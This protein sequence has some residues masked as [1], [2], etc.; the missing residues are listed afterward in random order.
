NPADWSGPIRNVLPNVEKINEVK[1]FESLPY[2]QVGLFMARLRKLRRGERYSK[3]PRGLTWCAN[4]NKWQVR[5]AKNRTTRIS[6][7]LFSDKEAAIAAYQDAELKMYRKN[8]I[9]RG[10]EYMMPALLLE[11]IILTGVRAGQ[12][13]NAR[14]DEIDW[15]NRLW[16]C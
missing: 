4:L 15:N 7:G 9:P 12:A 14:W 13:A 6:L 5:I 8:K 16:I 1:P 2:D 10:E 3:S 11:F